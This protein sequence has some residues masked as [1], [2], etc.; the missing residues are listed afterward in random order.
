MIVQQEPTVEVTE[1]RNLPCNQ[2]VY[3]V[4]FDCS[5]GA[6]VAE[7]LGWMLRVREAFLVAELAAA[8]VDGGGLVLASDPPV[9]AI[10]LGGSPPDNYPCLELIRFGGY[11]CRIAT[12]VLL[13][14]AHMIQVSQY[15]RTHDYSK[16]AVGG[17]AGLVGWMLWP[18]YVSSW[19]KRSAGV[20]CAAALR[21]L[22]DQATEA[23]CQQ[24]C[25]TSPK[26]SGRMSLQTWDF[27]PLTNH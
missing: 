14:S 10:I 6:E 5:H 9:A 15:P 4:V 1:A 22:P 16:D 23:P 18:I 13:C 19:R 7:A 2:H 25:S 17:S 21:R 12:V 26:R 20:F 3:T 8:L 27:L 24:L 11:R